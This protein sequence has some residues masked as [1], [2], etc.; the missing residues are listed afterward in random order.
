MNFQIL[1]PIMTKTFALKLA[2]ALVLSLAAIGAAQAASARDLQAGDKYGYNFRS[3]VPADR[4]GYDFR[5]HDTFTDGARSGKADP[6]TDGA[7]IAGLD[8]S[9]VSA[10]P[11]RGFDPYTE[12]ARSGKADPYTEGANA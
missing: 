8:R 2:S 9:G 1:E 4:Y 10:T 5:T 12:G 11:A 3:T 6:F 7:R